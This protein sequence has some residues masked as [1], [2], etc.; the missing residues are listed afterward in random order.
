M[1]MLY[2]HEWQDPRWG[3]KAYHHAEVMEMME[4]PLEDELLALIDTHWASLSYSLSPANDGELKS[5]EGKAR[6]IEAVLRD[7]AVLAYL[8]GVGFISKRCGGVESWQ[9]L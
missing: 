9:K 7:G 6:D 2:G 3:V 5:Y 8:V 4:L 1:S